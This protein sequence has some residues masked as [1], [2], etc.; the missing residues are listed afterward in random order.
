MLSQKKVEAR[1]NHRARKR[2]TNSHK[3]KP[4]RRASNSLIVGIGASAGGLEAFKTFFSNMPADSGMSF[5]L[6][7]H[8]SPDHK[9]MLADLVGKATAMPVIEAENNMPIAADSV[10]VIPPDATLTLKGRS[11]RVSR[12]A[13]P[14]ER[15]RPID[16]FFSSLA[17]E[18][19]ENAVCIV[20][21]GTGSDGTLGLKTIKENGGLTFAQAEVD[22]TAKS[23]MPQSATATGLVDEVMPVGDMPAKLLDYQNH[24]RKVAGQKSGDGTRTD[25][26]DHLTRI[27][28]LLRARVGHDFSKYKEKTLI[29]RIQRRMQVLQI[30]TVQDYVTR[31][32]EDPHQVELLFRELLIG[33][34]QFFRDPDAFAAMAAT[35]IPKILEGAGADDHI[36]IWV[37]GCATGEEVYSIAILVKE[38]L[39]GREAVPSVQIFGT[40]IDDNAVAVARAGRYRKTSG[41]SAARLARWFAEDG[42]EFCPIKPIREMCVFSTHSV[43]KDPP[44]SRL[45]LISCRNLLIYMDANL[46]DRILQTFHYALNPDGILF[47]GPAEGVTRQFKRFGTLDKKHRIYQRLSADRALPELSASPAPPALPHSIAASTTLHDA[48]KLGRGAKRIADKYSPAYLVVDERNEIVR[49]SGGEAGQ[50][51]EPASGAASFRLFDMLRKSLRPVVRAALQKARTSKEP[52]VHD[53]VALRINGLLQS[54][55]VI[56]E[57][58]DE[59]GGNSGHCVIVL[60]N[61]RRHRRRADAESNP[62]SDDLRTLEHELRT[63]KTQLQ[64]TIDDLETANEEMKSAAEEHQSVNEELQSSNEE[65][66]TSKEEMQSINE[67][68]QTINTEMAHKNEALTRAN[69]DLKNLLDSTEIATIFLDNDLR[70]KNFTPGMADIFRLRDSDRG[71]PITDIATALSYTGMADDAR[72]VLRKL[73]VIE[74]EVQL[75]NS[76]MTFIMRIRPYRTV[77]NAIDG[78]VITFVDISDRRRSQDQHEVLLHEMN[79]RVKNALATVQSIAAQSFRYT[80]T[81]EAFQQTFMSR[82]AALAKTHDT[83]TK[84]HWETAPLRDLLAAELEPYGGSDSS[85]FILDGKKVQLSSQMALAFGLVFHE[86]ATNAVKYGALS[87]PTGQVEIAWQVDDDKHRLRLHWKETGGPPVNKPGRR[88]MGSRVIES[89]LMHEFGGQ[90]RI[91]FNPAG[92]ECSIDMPLPGY[93]DAQ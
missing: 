39:N 37:P 49:F 87:V 50:Y 44:F 11:L 47:L 80:D 42:E 90:A 72:T 6:V 31:L 79:H 24:L 73:S 41:V 60:Q 56:V 5:V 4:S 55:S 45:D 18:Q 76:R 54:L 43:V 53:D 13:P 92:V 64:S 16:A 35:A 69:S 61:L 62:Q 30:D 63:T 70:I 52:A 22:H 89:G 2:A 74:Q 17:E 20:L 86:L 66:E 7:Q 19:G 58:I 91:D 15:R 78:V 68:L 67:E 46:Q 83:L 34:T 93:G 51:L 10:Y 59:R 1:K 29:R 26:A 21:S 3:N 75:K 40:D 27:N 8:L 82:L 36:R 81:R 88:G 77:D 28:A 32:R 84:S 71:R 38:A 14:R 25:A 12:P 57:P 9:S 48:D 65:L 85:R 33:V 23:G